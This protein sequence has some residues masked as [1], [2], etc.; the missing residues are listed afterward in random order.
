MP[1]SNFQQRN[2]CYAGLHYDFDIII[3]DYAQIFSAIAA[4]NPTI[5]VAPPMYFQMV[6]T[7]FLNM[8]AGKQR[9]WMALG[10][11]IA[12][13]PGAGLRRGLARRAF[14]EFYRQFG[15]RMRL[16]ITGMA[17]IK[18]SISEFFDRMQL[19]LAESY[20]WW[21]SGSLTYRPP[22]SKK[23]RFGGKAAPGCGA[24]HRKRWRNHC[25]PPALPHQTLFPVRRRGK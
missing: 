16:L 13:L 22:G 19:P 2:M 5:L 11:L 17:P 23:I 15:S 18:R 10:A 3:T 25:P 4:L 20:A 7:R 14:P 12:L 24:S 9:A 1:M 6:H 8:P 21:K